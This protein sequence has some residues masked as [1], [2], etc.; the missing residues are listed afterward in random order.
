MPVPFVKRLASQSWVRRVLI[1]LVLIGAWQ[2]LARAIDNDLLLPTF[3]ATFIAF[4][5]GILSG[6]LLQ[7]IAVSMSVLLRGYL[8]GVAC[9]VLDPQLAIVE[10]TPEA[11]RL[12]SGALTRGLSI[13]KALCGDSLE[14]PIAQALAAGRPA[15]GAIVRPDATGALHDG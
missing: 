10:A 11:D 1:A 4:V 15:S 13:V 6:E 2:A 14:R 12:T 7:K 9:A 3:G 5:Q 8:L